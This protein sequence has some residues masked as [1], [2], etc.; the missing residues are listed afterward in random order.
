MSDS[1]EEI[2][3]KADIVEL[4]SE[5]IPV[6]KS[7]SSYVAVC[8]FHNDTKPSMY[9]SSTKGIFK[10]FAC[11]AGGDLFKFW[12]DYYQKDFKESLKELAQK[13]GVELNL[14]Q[15]SKE[16]VEKFNLE[17]QMHEIAATYYHD[18]LMGSQDAA[19]ARKYI[20]ERKLTTVTVNQFK[21]GFA[22]ADANDW[23]K[24]IKIL[25]TKLNV[26]EEQIAEAGLALKSERA[27]RY[28]DRFRGRLMI[29]IQDER[30]RV[31][32]FGA[33]LIPGMDGDNGPKYMNSPETKIYHKGNNLYG[34]HH[35]KEFIRKEDAVIIVE[36]YFDLISLY[37]AG[38][39]NVL[40][41][42]GTALT[43]R[44]VK[45][46]SKF[47]ESKRI[48]LAF[49]SDEAGEKAGDRAAEIIAK[50]LG[51]YDY[52]LRILKVPDGKDADDYVQNHGRDAFLTLIKDAPFL[53]DYKI[54][55]IYSETDMSSPQNKAKAIK[56]LAKY[57]AYIQ[58]QI[59]LT[60]YI[61]IIAAKFRIDEADLIRE[62]SQEIKEDPYPSK[63]E[64]KP[65][66]KTK[67]LVNGHMIHAQ[68]PIF[69][70]EQEFL[71][72]AIRDKTVLE[73]FLNQ[74]ASLISDR[75]QKI[76]S[77]LTDI[78]FENPYL[79]DA[80]AKFAM[81]SANLV[82]DRDLAA[83]LADL[84]VKLEQGKL[85]DDRDER[86]AELLQRLKLTRL[87]KQMDQIKEELTL[88]HDDSDEWGNKAQ[89]KLTLE[90]EIQSLKSFRHPDT[91]KS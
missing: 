9:I 18:Q 68:D 14:S 34:I 81:L 53:T 41:N 6:K 73:E 3:A 83:D 60:E 84:G 88:L 30:G 75:H 22:V 11:G 76:L 27:N 55:K 13:Y 40:A 49:D 12:Q 43:E 50:I 23:G 59:E 24:L 66:A 63:Q 79:D 52:E 29:P 44:Q 17:I 16:D 21:L 26:T 33:R 72:L 90:K 36:G 42:Q 74:D 58:N 65:Q 54:N 91:M 82:H 1:V 4:I 19:L 31:I 5:V 2:K 51:K 85:T 7:G 8:P 46:L 87:K 20:E 28:F 56:Y 89:A 47:S 62:L 38:I 39:K 71:C 69:A 61:R 86:F 70:I 35:S 64:Q 15:D 67:A 77:A 80:E 37:Q 32:A 45:T 10:C 25:Q 78:S 57:L 48:Y